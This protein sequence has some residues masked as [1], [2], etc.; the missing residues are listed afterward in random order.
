MVRR[1][2][3]KNT[4]E[5]SELGTELKKFFNAESL[6]GD[7]AFPV[8]AMRTIH[9]PYLNPAERA[10][11]FR[12]RQLAA[13]LLVAPFAQNKLNQFGTEAATTRCLPQRGKKPFKG[14]RRIRNSICGH[15]ADSQRED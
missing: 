11:C 8:A 9:L 15:R 7:L 5:P 1:G 10:W 2:W 14:I 13:S 4:S 12:A 3:L 6:D